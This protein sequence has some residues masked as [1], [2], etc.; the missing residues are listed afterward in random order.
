MHLS[1]FQV[2]RTEVGVGKVQMK[3]RKESGD[4]QARM[5]FPKAVIG[6][7]AC[8]LKGANIPF[9]FLQHI[10][11]QIRKKMGKNAYVQCIRVL[12]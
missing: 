7:L 12:P 3:G 1:R 2:A 4:T 8:R 9:Q 6:K 11:L 5:K 10:I